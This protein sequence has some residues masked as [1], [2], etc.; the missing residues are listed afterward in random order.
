MQRLIRH[1]AINLHADTVKQEFE[2]FM[3]KDLLPYFGR[4]YRGPTRVSLADLKRQSLLE[5]ARLPR[6]YLWVTEWEGSTEAVAGASFAGARMMKMPA[7][8][9]MLKR[10]EGYG[11]RGTAKVFRELASAD[12]ATNA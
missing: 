6:R 7:T 10:L 8:D 12:V 11:R 9:A 3:Q 1:D 4:T 2:E 5:D